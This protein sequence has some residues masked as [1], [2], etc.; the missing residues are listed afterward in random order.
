MRP[1]PITP[2]Y[3]VEDGVIQLYGGDV[4]VNTEGSIR[5]AP[6]QI[7]LRLNPSPALVARL[8]GPVAVSLGLE[9][10]D[11]SDQIQLP[12]T[13]TL[14]PSPDFSLEGSHAEFHLDELQAGDIGSASCLLF[15]VLGEIEIDQPAIELEGGG[16]QPQIDFCL[17]GWDLTLVPAESPPL[18]K[19]FNMLVKAV[20][21]GPAVDFDAFERL[22]RQLFILLGFLANREIGIGP[23]C[24][25]DS[26]GN[27]VWVYWEPPRLRSG[28]ALTWCPRTLA[29]KAVV[30]LASRFS[31]LRD[32]RTFE[33]I[34]DRAIGFSLA[35]NGD[36]VLDVKVP[37]ACSGLELLANAVLLREGFVAERGT[38]RRLETGAAVRLLLKWADIPTEIPGEL[39][40][41]EKLR[42][43]EGHPEWGGPEVLFV[44]RNRLVHPPRN[45]KDP[46]WPS[47]DEMMSAWLLGTWYLE[48]GILRALG[49]DGDYLSRIRPS[50]SPHDLV[51]V[52]WGI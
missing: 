36:E 15:H 23:T 14:R 24:G 44:L 45:L 22:H 5:R 16:Q 32:D 29:A 26:D 49:Y 10:G 28:R 30:E 1:A 11:F 21:T 13:A 27:P 48:L 35:A 33:E 20:P 17:P 52:P 9:G 42:G 46:E 18:P 25:L 19:D 31:D 34:L 6:G 4:E 12:A 7:E 38:I 40:A 41:L 2:I 8:G 47:P 37:M 43:R 50:P 39:E 51:P 3:R